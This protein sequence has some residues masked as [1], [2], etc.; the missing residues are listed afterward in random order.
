[1][2]EKLKELQEKVNHQSSI[3]HE[4]VSHLYSLSITRN[5][6]VTFSDELISC[7]IDMRDRVY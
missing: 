5:E 4:L 2:E 3:I 6:E 7:L 1:M